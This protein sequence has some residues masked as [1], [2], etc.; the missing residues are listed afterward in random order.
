LVHG[1]HDILPI[2]VELWWKNLRH[3]L[4]RVGLVHASRL[5]NELLEGLV[6]THRLVQSAQEVRIELLLRILIQLVVLLEERL[7]GPDL[8]Q[9][10]IVIITCRSD[11]ATL[12]A[13]AMRWSHCFDLLD[14]RSSWVNLVNHGEE[15]S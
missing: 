2:G 6:P 1:V 12:V 10:S 3:G 7:L 13:P 11:P 15:A 14:D 8:T 9:R 4:G 5:L